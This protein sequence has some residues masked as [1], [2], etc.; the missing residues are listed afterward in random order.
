MSK[1]GKS[2]TTFMRGARSFIVGDPGCALVLRSREPIPFLRLA[3]KNAGKLGK[4]A[5]DGA[6]S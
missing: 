1:D 4:I 6:V 2:E 5:P 3:A